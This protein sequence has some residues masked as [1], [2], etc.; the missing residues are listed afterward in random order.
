MSS[1]VF[2]SAIRTASFVCR[3]I[4]VPA[5]AIAVLSLGILTVAPQP[6]GALEFVVQGIS[7]NPEGTVTGT[8]VSIPVGGRVIIGARVADSVSEPVLGSGASYYGWDPNI[9]SFVAG[10]A[11][12]S[13]FHSECVPGS[14][15]VG[16]VDNLVPSSLIETVTGLGGPFPGEPNVRVLV[17]MSLLPEMALANDSG[18]DGVCGGGDAQFRVTFAGLSEGQS[19]IVIGT[20]DDEDGIVVLPNSVAQ[21]SNTTVTV[22]VVPEPG[23]AA[24]IASGFFFL[25]ALGKPRN[26]SRNVV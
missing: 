26:I 21:A 10:N 8:D 14:S 23:L 11:V 17:E 1:S 7:V 22:T 13:L 19:T 5:T 12:D 3:F 18:L 20:G 16:G 2:L 15:G 6:A 24:S 25:V 4:L 9:L